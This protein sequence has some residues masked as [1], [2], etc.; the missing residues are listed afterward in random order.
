M[1]IADLETNGLLENVTKVHCASFYDLQTKKWEIFVPDNWSSLCFNFETRGISELT[2]YLDTIKEVSFHNS[3]GFDLKVLHKLY[4]YTYKGKVRDTLLMSR[5]LFPDIESP[6][7]T[8]DN[9]K[10]A[11]VKG[12]HSVEAWGVRLGISKPKH[13]D[14]SEFS[15]EMLHR[16]MEDVKIQAAIYEHILDYIDTLM[17]KDKRLDMNQVWDVEHKIWKFIE[18]Q[19][20]YGWKFDAP[21]AY[22]LAEELQTVVD[23]IDAELIPLLPT[24]VVQP[25]K[26]P[27]SA[28]LKDGSLGIHAVKWVESHGGNILDIMGDFSRV[29]FEKMNLNSDTQVKEYL[30][31]NGWK[32]T[33]WNYKKDNHNKIIRNYKQGGRGIKTSPKLPEN[34]EEWDVVIEKIN[35]PSIKLLGERGKAAH[36][37]SSIKGWIAATRPDGR[38]EARANTC[39]TNTARFTHSVV[40]NVPKAE[41]GVYYGK[42]MRSLF[43]ASDNNVLVGIDASALEARCEAHYI[44]KFDKDSAHELVEGDIHSRNAAI[45]DCSRG[46]AKAGKYCLVYG[47]GAPKL[48]STLGKPKEMAQ[49]LY[50][51]YWSGNPGLKQLKKLVEAAWQKYGYLLSIDKRPLTIRYKHAL[52]NTLFQSCGSIAMKI[53]L[54]IF[55]EEL[56]KRKLIAPS[57]GNFHDEWQRDCHPAIAEDVGK[58]G[59]WSIE[60][61]SRYLNLNVQLT[62]E[63]KIGASWAA[64]H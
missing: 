24:R 59:V 41:E 29:S 61:A 31:A 62:G 35:I 10:T 36:R 22:D 30:L 7:Y 51:A 23:R 15:A 38:I 52:I 44:Y 28:F 14:W 9:G 20:D 4:N 25:Y 6:S 48:A 2:A 60:E 40:V 8:R 43:I 32:P 63:Y 21:L 50:N 47:G 53:A 12:P 55:E 27:V 34:A 57:V 58:V 37:L 16:N 11:K 17:V 49:E 56:Q 19:A 1:I 5:I 26:G 3:Y 13:E 54:I 64:T 18:Q 46:K 39:S 42:Q 33:Q 45:F